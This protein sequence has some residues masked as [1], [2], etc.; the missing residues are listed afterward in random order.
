MILYHL[1]C[2]DDAL[3]SII[4]ILVVVEGMYCNELM[5]HM[6]NEAQQ[7]KCVRMRK[8]KKKK[9]EEIEKNER[10]IQVNDVVIIREQ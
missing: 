1:D 3:L 2:D 5:M 7:E 6:C 8:E 4:L 10:M 9:K